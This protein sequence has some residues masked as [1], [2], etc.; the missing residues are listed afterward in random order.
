MIASK[1]TELPTQEGLLMA[2]G[3]K[4]GSAPTTVTI[5]GSVWDYNWK[6][7]YQG[8]REFWTVTDKN[9]N[10]GNTGTANYAPGTKLVF[11]DGEIILGQ[12][13]PTSIQA[14]P[15]VV[16]TSLDQPVSYTISGSDF[17]SKLDISTLG[18]PNVG[19]TTSEELAGSWGQHGNTRT[20]TYT[21]DPR[22]FGGYPELIALAEGETLTVRHEIAVRTYDFWAGYRTTSVPV[23]IV[24]SGK[25]DAPKLITMNSA[26]SAAEDGTAVVLN[27][28]TFADDVDSDDDGS[29][30]RYEIVS[31]PDGFDLSLEGTTLRLDPSDVSQTMTS[32]EKI[33]GQVVLRAIDR[34]GVAATGEIKINL[35]IQGVDDERQVFV[36]S[37]GVDYEALGVSRDDAVDYGTVSPYSS[38]AI[39]NELLA[40]TEGE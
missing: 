26:L 28:A 34:H 5:A 37:T 30:L 16:Y 20:V 12:N 9:L 39:V 17:D 3:G 32:D 7:G 13:S 4:G 2:K 25:N 40:F 35:S 21:F 11:T 38:P 23:D 24:I 15:A 27:L 22:R 8:S 29:T 14:P 10:D 31:A 36:T 18:H 6:Q 1:L 33:T 19:S